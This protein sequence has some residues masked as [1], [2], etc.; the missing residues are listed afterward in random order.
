M[1]PKW[2]KRRTRLAGK[3]F[4]II[5]VSLRRRRLWRQKQ[6]FKNTRTSDTINMPNNILQ[7]VSLG[8]KSCFNERAI[9]PYVPQ[10]EYINYGMN[11]FCSC[12]E[13]IRQFLR[14]YEC[15][16]ILAVLLANVLK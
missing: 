10:R 7:F 3:L 2:Q 13:T 5:S 14:K 4:V 1:R 11:D 15:K 9:L 8:E 16:L 12:V 6:R